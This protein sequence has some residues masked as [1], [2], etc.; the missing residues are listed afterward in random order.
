[1]AWSE[2]DITDR[3]LLWLGVSVILLIDCCCGSECDITDRLLFWLGVSVILLIDCCCG[4][5]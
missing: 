1:M 3:V 2:C 4:L 5:E